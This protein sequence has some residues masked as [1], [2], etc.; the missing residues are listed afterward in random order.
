MSFLRAPKPRVPAKPASFLARLDREGEHGSNGRSGRRI[1]IEGEH[2][3]ASSCLPRPPLVQ[4]SLIGRFRFGIGRDRPDVLVEDAGELSSRFL[5]AR[6]R[7]RVGGLHSPPPSLAASFAACNPAMDAIRVSRSRTRISIYSSG[8]FAGSRSACRMAHLD[9]REAIRY[10]PRHPAA[11][12]MT[13]L[14]S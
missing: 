11:R 9:R 14:L 12:S 2:G 8:C 7:R 5:D 1:R 4:G 3:R 10:R 13:R 6:E